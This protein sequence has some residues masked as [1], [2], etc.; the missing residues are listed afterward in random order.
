MSALNAK[1]TAELRERAHKLGLYGLLA[2]WDEFANEAAIG[3]LVAAEEDERARR[4]IE[5]RLRNAKLGDFKSINDFDWSWPKR[6]ER[7]VVEE[8]LRLDFMAEAANV[9]L[10]GP[11]GVGKTTIAQNIAYQAL[12]RGHGALRVS[13]SEMLTNLTSQEGSAALARRLRYYAHPALLVLDEIGYLPL[14]ARQGDLFFEVVSRRHEAKKPIVLTTNKPFSE[15][16]QVFAN[17]SCVTAMVD[18]LVHRVEIVS[19]E[20]ESYR[21]KEAKERA[22]RKQKERKKHAGGGT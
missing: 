15:W 11:N 5:R 18:R 3:R 13:A 20:G 17:A 1:E 22:A 21:A 14:G 16:N 19:I 6:V 4:S 7:A 2:H 12:L 10:I 8:L 9:V